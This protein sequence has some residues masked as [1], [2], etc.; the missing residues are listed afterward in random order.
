MRILPR[1]AAATAEAEEV[2][3]IVE[4]DGGVVG[5]HVPEEVGDKGLDE[6]Q[7]ETDTA[8]RSRAAE[9]P[10]LPD[11]EA[12]SGFLPS[13]VPL[14]SLP[15][16][17]VIGSPGISIRIPY[18]R[19]S[20]A[21]CSPRKLRGQQAGEPLSAPSVGELPAQPPVM[22]D[23][24][25]ECNSQTVLRRDVSLTPLSPA[26]RTRSTS[27]SVAEHEEQ[28]ATSPASDLSRLPAAPPALHAPKTSDTDL[29]RNSKPAN[30]KA[31]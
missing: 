31:V 19:Q 16:A 12:P 6:A 22:R 23:M 11:R 27:G 3:A 28:Q 1:G 24:S 20:D 9:L 26:A 7:E 15:A 14:P 2:A 21:A 8:N 18:D 4:P 5:T 13:S 30:T 10:N 25:A 17:A 29:R